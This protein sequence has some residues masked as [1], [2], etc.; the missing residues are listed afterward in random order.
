MD[1]DLIVVNKPDYSWAHEARPEACMVPLHCCYFKYLF[2]VCVCLCVTECV[3]TLHAST[4]EGQ[5]RTSDALEL[6]SSVVVR[7]PTW[8]LG[9]DPGSSA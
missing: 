1:G 8:V 7:C 2:N 4:F 5:E 3:Y 9:I 6:E